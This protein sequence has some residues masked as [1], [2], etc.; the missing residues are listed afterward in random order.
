LRHEKAPGARWK[1]RAARSAAR[2]LLIAVARPVAIA[3][4]PF[5]GTVA[6]VIVAP[7]ALGP[8]AVRSV[9]RPLV[10]AI[11]IHR[12]LVSIPGPIAPVVAPVVAGVAVTRLAIV[13]ARIGVALSAARRPPG[14]LAR[15]AR[16]GG[17]AL[18]LGAAS[19]VDPRGA[20]A[21]VID[22][23]WPPPRI[24][25]AAIILLHEEGH[26][27][28]RPEIGD[29]ATIARGGADDL[30]VAAPGPAV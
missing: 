18:G 30:A 9:A 23:L 11:R 26:R 21:P 5:A 4:A 12:A 6:G 8:L 13:A 19:R 29:A 28:T 25:E 14:L 3:V 16:L 27:F 20:P 10:V 22:T 2:C 1:A 7:G 24:S 15:A 17:G